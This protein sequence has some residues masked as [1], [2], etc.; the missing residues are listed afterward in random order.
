M[1]NRF[2]DLLIGKNRQS[3][4]KALSD[5]YSIYPDSDPSRYNPWDDKPLKDD[6]EE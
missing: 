2:I 6:K 5:S 4:K 3:E 1:K